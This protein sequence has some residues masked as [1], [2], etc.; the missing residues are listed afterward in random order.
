MNKQIALFD[1][2]EEPIQIKFKSKYQKWKY[3]NKYRKADYLSDIRCQNCKNLFRNQ[4][5]YKCKLL[6]ISGS[7]A[8]DIRLSNVCQNFE[9]EGIEDE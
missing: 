3:E 8:T 4:K 7:S 1:I 6:G 2:D 5:Y 9:I